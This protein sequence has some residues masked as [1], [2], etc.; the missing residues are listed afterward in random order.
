MKF[1]QGY[2]WV[3]FD[4]SDQGLVLTPD[5]YWISIA[6]KGTPILNWFYSYGKPVGPIDGTR[7]KSTDDKGWD[8]NLS[9]EFNFRIYGYI[10]DEG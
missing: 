1:Q 7:Y 4:F 2:D 5:K 6:Q 8:K 3:E 10:P 9:F